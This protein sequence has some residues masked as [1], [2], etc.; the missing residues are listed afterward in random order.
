MDFSLAA[1]LDELKY[2]V[3]IPDR[4]FSGFQRCIPAGEVQAPLVSIPDRDFS[5]FQL[6]DR[7]WIEPIFWNRVSIPDRDFS[8]FQQKVPL[9][10]LPESLFQSLI[11]ILVDFS[12]YGYH[13]KSSMA[14]RFN[15]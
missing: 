1:C 8:G 7:T 4:D 11:G 3:S 12:I 15:P 13:A 10:Q 2:K 5:G 9:E 6:C 14:E